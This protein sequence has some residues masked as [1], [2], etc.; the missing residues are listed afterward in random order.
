MP[1]CGISEFLSMFSR[2]FS[3]KNEK[4]IFS[5]LPIS[6]EIFTPMCQLQLKPIDGKRKRN[7]AKKLLGGANIGEITSRPKKLSVFCFD[8]LS[9]IDFKMVQGTLAG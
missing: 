4:A 7:V 1:S 8:P 5:F 6:G 9:C 2:L 3:Q